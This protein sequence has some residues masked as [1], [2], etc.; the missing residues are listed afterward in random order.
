M[1]ARARAACCPGAENA[2]AARGHQPRDR[3]AVSGDDV[4]RF[5]LDI[6]KHR[7]NARFASRRV[8]VLLV[9]GRLQRLP[10]HGARHPTIK[11]EIANFA[12]R[13]L[14]RRIAL[15]SLVDALWIDADFDP[16]ALLLEDHRRAR[17]TI[18]P[19]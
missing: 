14:D 11:L 8:I 3:A 9:R 12:T 19:A 6:A 17:I 10:R 1:R 13:T 5:G 4:L 7:A 18:A 16:R 2:P 15:Q